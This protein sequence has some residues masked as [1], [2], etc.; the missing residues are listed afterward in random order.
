MVHSF[1]TERKM[2]QTKRLVLFGIWQ[3]SD[4]CYEVQGI[5][6]Q[7]KEVIIG[8]KEQQHI[9]LSKVA[10]TLGGAKPKVWFILAQTDR[11]TDSTTT[12]D[13]SKIFSLVYLNA[14]FF[15][16]PLSW[17]HVN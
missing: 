8:L 17:F 13:N 14:Q 6:V 4:C 15:F 2:K 3:L 9:N 1:V 7:V 10:K 5:S 11:Q 12:D 16:H